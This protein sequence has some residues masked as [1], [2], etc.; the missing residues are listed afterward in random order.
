MGK[1]G[2][3][4]LVA[5]KRTSKDCVFCRIIEGELPSVKLYEDDK[6]IAIEDINRQAPFHALLI[7]KEHVESLLEV[8]DWRIISH[9]FE[10]IKFLAEEYKLAEKGF[11][12]VNNCGDDGG[13][14]IYH[15]HF[16]LLGGRSMGW[17]PG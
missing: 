1:E 3:G 17:P 11:R 6:I 10:I 8:K 15:L 2:A 4:K 16:H 7:S 5:E 14:T 12:V 13:Q 9:I